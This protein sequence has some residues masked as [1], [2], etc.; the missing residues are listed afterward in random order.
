MLRNDKGTTWAYRTAE[1]PGCG[2]LTVEVAQTDRE[3]ELR[4]NWLKI[5]R[6]T[7]NERASSPTAFE[8]LRASAR[9]KI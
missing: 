1:C 6:C 9:E 3:G 7:P 4:G 8:E 5:D 2:E